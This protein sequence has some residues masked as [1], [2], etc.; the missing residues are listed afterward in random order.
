M[1]LESYYQ[2]VETDLLGHP[3]LAL[4]TSYDGK[5]IWIYYKLLRIVSIV[6]QEALF[7]IIPF[8]LIGKWQ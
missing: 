4:T 1:I 6:Y 8:P 2:N 5:N 7:E 3:R